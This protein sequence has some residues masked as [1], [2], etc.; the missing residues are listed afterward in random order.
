M[1]PEAPSPTS[2]RTQSDPVATHISDGPE[3]AALDGSLGYVE[4]GFVFWGQG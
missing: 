2:P 3:F 4:A 1:K